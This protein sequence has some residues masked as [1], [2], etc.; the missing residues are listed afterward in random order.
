MPETLP[1][2]PLQTVLLPGAN[3]PLHIFEPRY[4][5]LTVDLVKGVVPDK[6]F[7]VAAIRTPLIEEV[8]KPDQLAAVGCSAI[9]RQATRLGDGRYDIV[10]TGERRFRLLDL[11]AT[12]AP[13][14]IGTVEWIPD[15][16][17]P[18]AKADRVASLERS[19]RAAYRRYCETAWEREDW[20]EPD[21][22]TDIGNLAHLLAADCLLP[23]E[24]RQTLLEEV[25]PLHRLRMVYSLLTREAGIIAALRAVP[26][27]ASAFSAPMNLN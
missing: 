19:A 17:I 12:S 13:Y 4:R 11:D 6:R 1:L 15:A 9:L 18:P 20:T 5:Q 27:P 25:R 10:T 22:D 23:I 16:Q 2:F 3:L 14:L 7:G 26:A 24:D 21:E 8:D